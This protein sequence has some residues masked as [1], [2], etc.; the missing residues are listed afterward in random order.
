MTARSLPLKRR[1]PLHP[2][3]RGVDECAVAAAGYRVFGKRYTAIARL[4]DQQTV[5]NLDAASRFVA[6]PR[7]GGSL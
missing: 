1:Y 6:I 5:L 7:G 2:I 3:T 4:F